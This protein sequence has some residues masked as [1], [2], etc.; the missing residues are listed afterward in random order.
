MS[1]APDP[2]EYG[3]WLASRAAGVL[4]LVCVAASVG[5]GL[6]M[7]GRV[8]PRRSRALL[9][10]HQQ[11]AL[12]GLLAI[13]VHGITLLGD[14]FLRPGLKGIAVPFVMDHEPLWTGLGITG[15]W[16]AAILGLSYWARDRIGARLWRRLHRATL[17]VYVL[18]VAHTLGSGT[19]AGEP[20][21]LLLIAATGAPVL[22][23]FVMRV[24]PVPPAPSALRRFRVEEIVP[25]SRS[26]TSFLLA[27]VDGLR[28]EP[29]AP[30]QFV[31]LSVDVPGAG[32]LT[33][34][35]SLSA[36][37]DPA[38]HRISV[39]HEDGGVVSGHLHTRVEVG[40]ALELGAPAGPFTLDEEDA[41]RP[42]VLISAGVGATPVLAMLGALAAR[43]SPR[44]VWWV[45]GA[46]CGAD[47][48]FR[49]EARDL[50]ALLP[51]ARGHVR[52]SRP[53]ARDV[54]G[55]DFDAPGRVTAEDVLELGVP[56][57]ADVRIC[58]PAAFVAELTEGLVRGGIASERIA[59]ESFAAPAA[60]SVSFAR[61]G[62]TV[63][64]D[65]RFSSLLEL[66]EAHDVPAASSCRVGVC[67]G[68][69]T[70]VREGQVRH[71][72]QAAAPPQDGAALLCCAR[73]EGDLVLDL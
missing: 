25:E 16:L 41:R 36:A 72:P 60:P 62:R 49:Q 35:Y 22:F 5:L 42:V 56:L 52:Y 32:A 67:H 34:C 40:D 19:D 33:R 23:L 59:G 61:S 27:P 73:P 69:R 8:S 64:W 12:A 1:G 44:P 70:G 29:F 66:A 65:E 68:C 24:L 26:V 28:L 46:R 21:L 3:W 20:W 45:H 6:A 10:L 14:H 58:G 57:E 63:P 48:A 4:A 18:A 43:C 30:G 7:A 17:L 11:T 53:D 71:D 2:A 15:G 47:H 55:R 13:A 9:A 37:P 50:L 39:K 54:V 38:R 31:S 51:D